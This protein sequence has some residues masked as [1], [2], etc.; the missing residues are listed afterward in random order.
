[1][2]KK[3]DDFNMV[4]L[5]GELRI[6]TAAAL[7]ALALKP[8]P[9]ERRWFSLEVRQDLPVAPIIRAEVTTGEG[10]R[11]ETTLALEPR[12]GVPPGTAFLITPRGEHESKEDWLKRCAAITGLEKP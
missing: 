2:D 3:D 8:L 9:L 5:A 12:E 6:P 4:K 10:R 7:T 1:M 11:Y